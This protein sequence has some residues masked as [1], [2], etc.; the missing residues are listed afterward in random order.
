[1]LIAGKNTQGTMY[2]LKKQSL[3]YGQLLTAK[4]SILCHMQNNTFIT[5]PQ[6]RGFFYTYLSQALY[7]QYAQKLYLIFV[8][9]F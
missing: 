5:A 7:I 3:E 2:R 4:K 9:I 8:H 6:M 1:L